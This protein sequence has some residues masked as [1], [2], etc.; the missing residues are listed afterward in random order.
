MTRTRSA[1]AASALAAALTVPLL[2]SAP[3]SATPTS[4]GS[5]PMAAPMTP[6][7]DAK[8]LVWVPLAAVAGHPRISPGMKATIASLQP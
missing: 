2:A 6:G 8:E 3:A 7:D 4:P 5:S 1:L